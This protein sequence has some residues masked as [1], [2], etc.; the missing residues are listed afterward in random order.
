MPPIDTV[1]VRADACPGER[2]MVCR[3]PLLAERRAR[4]RAELLQATEKLLQPIAAATRRQIQ[5]KR[6]FHST[7]VHFISALKLSNKPGPPL[8]CCRP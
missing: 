4:K 3:N 7:K 8:C 5:S 2:L 1:E 6:A